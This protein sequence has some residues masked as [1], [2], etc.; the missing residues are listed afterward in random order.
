MPSMGV[1]VHAL[2]SKARTGSVI[3]VDISRYVCPTADGNE[4]ERGLCRA[5]PF[6]N[7]QDDLPGFYV[8]EGEHHPSCD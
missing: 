7:F 6:L 4:Y 5:R 1:G 3:Y 2:Q 8:F